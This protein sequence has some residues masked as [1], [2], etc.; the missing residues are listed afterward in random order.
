MNNEGCI[1]PTPTYLSS[2]CGHGLDIS[3]VGTINTTSNNR[4]I[5]HT[6]NRESGGVNVTEGSNNDGDLSQYVVR[7]LS[8]VWFVRSADKGDSGMSE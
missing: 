4:R 2:K 3:I 5:E 7:R 6:I 1:H 8:V